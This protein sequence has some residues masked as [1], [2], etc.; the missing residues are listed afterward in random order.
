MMAL[1]TS[2]G[3]LAEEF[4]NYSYKF[5]D[6]MEIGVLEKRGDHIRATPVGKPILNAIV[7]E[8]LA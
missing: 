4:L 6:L 7:R 8:L 5:N 2:E 1:R 3:L